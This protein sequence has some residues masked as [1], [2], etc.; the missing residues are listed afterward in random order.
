MNEKFTLKPHCYNV[1][2]VVG[3]FYRHLFKDRQEERKLKEMKEK[4]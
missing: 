1:N 4:T 2:C 3:C